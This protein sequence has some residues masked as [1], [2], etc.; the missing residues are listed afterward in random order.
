[1]MSAAS[2]S[3]GL[4]PIKSGAT[5]TGVAPGKTTK[6]AATAQSAQEAL[7]WLPPSPGGK[8]PPEW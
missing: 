4:P 6:F 3:T 1:M 8:S 7:G 5:L 2:F